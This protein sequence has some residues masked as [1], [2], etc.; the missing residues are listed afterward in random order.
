MRRVS[1]ICCAL[2]CIAAV[3]GASALDAPGDVVRSTETV[4]PTEFFDPA[5]VTSEMEELHRTLTAARA[6]AQIVDLGQLT[7]EEA[8]ILTTGRSTDT[9]RY[10]VGVDRGV[11]AIVDLAGMD[12]KA[13]GIGAV[14][15]LTDGMMVWT[16]SFRS[17]GATAVRAHLTDTDLPRGAQLF[18]YGEHGDA[19]GPYTGSG[20]LANSE[21]WTNTVIGDTITLQLQIQGPVT[22][23]QRYASYFVVESVGHMGERFE[24]AKWQGSTEQTKTHCTDS[25]GPVNADC[26]ENAECGSVGPA[27]AAQSA[28]A[29][30]LYKSGRN[31]YICTGGLLS[32]GSGNPPPYFL[33]ANHCISK[34]NEASSL[35]TYWDHT[36][37]CGTTS[38]DY[39]WAGGRTITGASILSTNRT[40]DYTLLQLASVPTG[41]AYLGWSNAAIAT[42]NGAGLHRISHPAGSPQ[43]YSTHDVD[44][45]AGTCQSWPRG[46]WIYSRDTHGATEG[47][48]SGSPVLNDSGQ[49]VGQLSGGCGT[50]VNETCDAVNNAT[51]DGA[52]AA[53]FGSVS[54]WLDGGTSCIPSTEVC[55]GVDNDCDG[56]I[57]EDDVCGGGGCTLGQVGDACTENADCCSNK[58]RGRSGNKTCR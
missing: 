56:E 43:A 47:G 20:S 33:T 30:M 23:A 2:A 12:E 5:Q 14:H 35:E 39:G 29:A 10:L 9:R 38:C 21:I 41:R 57:D 53:Y 19:F 25:S 4:L 8:E 3:S 13:G 11:N 28:V 50:N 55:D 46:N 52:L 1:L 17:P 16:A 7:V 24:L 34:G 42:Q 44:T 36:A 22:D 6:I 15:T 45:S 18:A 26:V 31:Y 58:C 48:S 54:Q 32:N 49:V 40:S 37:P 27:S 51:V